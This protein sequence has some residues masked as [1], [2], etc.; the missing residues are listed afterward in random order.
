MYYL[1]FFSLF[2]VCSGLCVSDL[3]MVMEIVELKSIYLDIFIVEFFLLFFLFPL[4]SLLLF[5]EHL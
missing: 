5:V 3:G 2:D 1:L 4:A